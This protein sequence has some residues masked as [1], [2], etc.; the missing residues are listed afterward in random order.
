MRFCEWPF[1]RIEL[2]S[3]P[4]LIIAAGQNICNRTL[5]PRSD[6]CQSKIASTD[7]L[8]RLRSC[9]RPLSPG[10]SLF[11]TRRELTVVTPSRYT[12]HSL[13]QS[14]TVSV[15]SAPSGTS[16]S[17]CDRHLGLGILRLNGPPKAEVVSSNLAGSAIRIE[18]DCR[19][20]P[21]ARC[22]WPRQ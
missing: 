15:D 17:P 6:A 5:V 18:Y 4:L 21:D 9:K 7:T 20:S 19:H 13:S 1:L 12:G 16:K 14:V 22:G 11:L 10:W 8:L 3:C 2:L